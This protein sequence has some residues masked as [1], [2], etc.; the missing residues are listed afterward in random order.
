MERQWQ[1]GTET[2]SQNLRSSISWAGFRFQFEKKWST[3]D[4]LKARTILCGLRQDTVV[5][6]RWLSHKIKL[7]H[8]FSYPTRKM[9]LE[10]TINRAFMLTM[11]LRIPCIQ[12][13]IKSN[14]HSIPES[15]SRICDSNHG[16][17]EWGW[18]IY[19]TSWVTAHCYTFTSQCLVF[20]ALKG[21]QTF[22]QDSISGIHHQ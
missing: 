4:K 16:H 11:P 3:E 9:Q 7:C 10:K 17:R 19:N 6:N 21:S 22:S 14:F 8:K 20:G 15:K 12:T 2:Q 5:G 1:E 13:F 18:Q